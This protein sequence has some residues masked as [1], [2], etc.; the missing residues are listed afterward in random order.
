[1]T[2]PGKVVQGQLPALLH[3]GEGARM[4]WEGG[5]AFKA[6]FGWGPGAEGPWAG[7]HRPPDGDF[8]PPKARGR[9]ARLLGACGWGGGR[10]A[11]I[12]YV[13]YTFVYTHCTYTAYI[14]VVNRYILHHVHNACDVYSV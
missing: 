12:V 10:P 6:V 4:L 7:G 5:A 11:R 1:M 14:G 13:P 9:G 2:P 8:H 3:C